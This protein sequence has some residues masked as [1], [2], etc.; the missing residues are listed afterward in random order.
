MPIGSNP[1]FDTMLPL[2]QGSGETVVLR[3]TATS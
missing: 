3:D 2:G 1:L